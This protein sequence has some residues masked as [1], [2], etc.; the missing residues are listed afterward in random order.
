[1]ISTKA[2]RPAAWL[3]AF[4]L[5]GPLRAES[6][7]PLMGTSE[8]VYPLAPENR[9]VRG[10]AFDEASP[11]APRLFVLDAGGK[12]FIYGVPPEASTA[13]GALKLLGSVPLP[14]R[15]DGRPLPGP[16]GL[17]YA[18]EKGRDVF[19]VL[20]WTKTSG[21]A[22]SEL[23]RFGPAAGSPTAI[24][25]SLYPYKVGDR[26]VVGLAHD[27]GHF[28]VSFDAGGY[29][30]ANLRVQRGIIRLAWNPAAEE[31]LD[32]VKHLPDAGTAPSYGLAFMTLDGARYVWGTV[33]REHLYCAEAET[34]RGL[35]HFDRPGAPDGR[36]EA[37]GL[38]FG[39]NALWVPEGSPGPDLVHR[40]NV[41]KNLDAA[42]EGPRILRHLQMTIATEPE[43]AAASA[44]RVFHN[45]SRPYAYAQLGNQGTWPESESVA[46]TSSAPNATAKKV[47]RDPAGDA[48]SR[49]TLAV[50]EYGEGP[51]RP[52]ASR[53]EIDLWTNP[54]RSYV[55]PHRVDR[56]KRA[57]KGTDYLA[58]D[59]VLYDLS[60]KKT[61]DE[62]LARVRDHISKKY[63]LPADLQ[64]P[65][66]AARNILEY[67]QDNYYYPSRPKRV[68]AAVDYGRRHYDANPGN[69][70]IELSGRPYDR[71]QII[72]CSGTSVM[73]AGA[74]RYL[75]IEA[76]W[77]GTGTAQGPSVWDQNGN[78]FLDPAETAPVTNGHRY[79]Q[80]WLGSHYGWVC[81]DATP[82]LPDDLDFDPAPPLQSQWRY[83]NRAA[84]GHL[85]DQRIVFNV[86]S[87]LIPE[88]YRDF[89]YDEELNVDNNCGGDQRYNL[90]G[91]FDK[92]E[93]WKL[94]R[95]SIS[96]RNV[97]FLKD[98][99]ATVAGPTM[100]VSWGL[101]GA[102]ARDPEARLEVV[103]QQEDPASRKFRD[104]AVLRESVLPAAGKVEV[105]AAAYSGRSF[106]VKIRKVGDSETGALSSVFDLK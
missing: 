4:V 29:K 47:V 95:H 103:L 3:A 82:T 74:L 71:T 12:V 23:W 50:V 59:P 66:W 40:V 32:F 27:S 69:L 48:S 13:A 94:A 9:E 36:P 88:L 45:Y 7:G 60:D 105:D 20:N 18:R 26:E 80:V 76:R 8:R 63:G 96:V 38:A 53:Y 97:C 100:T 92:P 49:Q 11:L 14:L 68:P 44:G 35:F 17:A 90:Q 56:D 87:G 6:K 55:Y 16:R 104:A 65:Y 57:L 2:L 91:K 24:D 81:F 5:V 21:E 54:S 73:V 37:S 78:G 83:M 34:G 64:H 70:K 72:A 46:D 99:A 28:L 43:G 77:L 39:A 10:L 31:V 52:Y 22:E 84:A 101:E 62:F 19:Y 33:G 51:A 85:K 42:V 86:G 93:L 89:E 30:D 1:M 67:I 98:V 75:G 58:D 79:D 102:W 106:R 61:Y 25:L 15:P 41:T